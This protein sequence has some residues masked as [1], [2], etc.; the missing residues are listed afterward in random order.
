MSARVTLVDCGAGNLLS[1]ARAVRHLG[2]EAIVVETPAAVEA[3]ER[4]ILPG[5]GAFAMCM[6]GLARN[7]L[8]DAVRLYAASGKP[9]LGICVGMQML[10]EGSD[11]F[12]AHAGLGLLPGWVRAIPS[13]SGGR[14]RKIP[15]IGWNGLRPA[16]GGGSWDDGLLVGVSPGEG[17]YFVHSFAAELADDS[18]RAAVCDYEGTQITAVVQRDNLHGCQFHPEKSGPG[19]LHILRN[20]LAL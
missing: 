9:F 4:L 18:D 16:N 6:A 15:H 2:A 10:F 8:D 14:Q 12:G 5:V 20:F 7:G 17:V 3:A 11:E 1:V 19:G 13:E